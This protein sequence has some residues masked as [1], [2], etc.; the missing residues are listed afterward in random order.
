M[1][2][3]SVRTGL[4]EALQLDL[5]G[6]SNDH[7]FA[8]ELLPEWPSRWYLTGFLVPS[9]APLEQRIDQTASEQIDSAGEGE[10]GDDAIEPDRGPARRSVLPSSMGLS[11]LVLAESESL[12]IEVA[13]GDYVHE[14][15]DNDEEVNDGGNSEIP[16]LKFDDPERDELSSEK[17]SR[18]ASTS[19]SGWRRVPKSDRVSIPLTTSEKP[20]Q[21]VLP[22]GGGLVLVV[23][24]RQV[25]PTA[26]GA[27]RIPADTRSVAVFLVNK[28][29]PNLK[30]A[31]KGF[32]FQASL[33][34]RCDNP[35]VPRPDLRSN[36]SSELGGEW[37]ELVAD[38]QYR[39]V[40]EYAVGHAVS[41]TADIDKDGNC[42]EV[43]T[44]W[45]PCADVEWI[46]PAEMPDVEIGMEALGSLVDGPDAS[47]RLRPLTRKY[48]KWIQQQAEMLAGLDE[49]RAKTAEDLLLNAEHAA[50]R[51]DAGIALLAQPEILDAFRV[52][53]RTMAIAARRRDAI[54]QGV[55]PETLSAPRWRPFQLAFILM[56]LQGIA[57]PTH[58]DREV[59]DLL[60][61]PTGG[62]KTEAYLGLAAFSMVLRRLRNPGLRSAGLSVLMR[63]TLRLLTLDQLGRAAALVCALE[64]ER[65]KDK[66]RLGEWP[67][68]IGLW[69][70]SAATPNR[71]GGHKYNG[72]GR[73]YTAYKKT[74]RFQQDDRNPAPIPLENCPWC[75]TK[76]TSKSFRLTPNSDH[77][78]D[79]RIICVNYKCDF[80]GDRSLPVLGVD[81]PIYRRLPAFLIAT[82]DKFAALPWTGETGAL[83]GLVERFDRNGFYGPCAPGMGQQLVGGHLPPPDLII[84]DELHLISGPLGTIAGVYETAI[85][86][87]ATREIDGKKIA[88][89]SG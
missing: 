7:P 18:A 22:N 49:Q 10:G 40:F 17:D 29:K 11:V 62:G 82:I 68:E 57:E 58:A 9:D 86:C 59:V 84:Q 89:D 39:D 14:G 6:P 25:S 77:P 12:D 54:Q 69:V 78:L 51:I 38:L 56:S 4:I 19:K 53:N 41:V 8:Q 72:P 88:E 67:F 34:V 42:F 43:R 65:D 55:A 71:M 85:D 50:R 3:S 20:R 30:S 37:D 27:E 1:N 81:E 83:F 26:I 2:S 16:D 70:G 87:L 73:E 46:A 24:V 79:L 5:I 74:T 32:A 52:A 33:T 21:V 47:D 35:F 80:S 64:L 45:V 60:F 28:R 66:P 63:Y 75:G 13:W 23:T 15:A 31:Y 76:F 36:F 44:T 61:F 48:R